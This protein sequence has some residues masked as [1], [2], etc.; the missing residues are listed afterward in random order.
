M[1]ALIFAPNLDPF[2]LLS[3]QI[4]ALSAMR[5]CHFTWSAI[6]CT[7]P[8]GPLQVCSTALI[9]TFFQS[10]PLGHTR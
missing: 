9:A 5:F 7:C 3:L 4:I 6:I 1:G 8:I 10:H 2:A